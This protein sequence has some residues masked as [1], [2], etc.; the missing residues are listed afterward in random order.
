MKF[1]PYISSFVFKNMCEMVK[2]RVRTEKGFKEVHL[3][4]LAKKVFEY[5][6]VEVSSQQVYNHLR[7][8]RTT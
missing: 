4:T 1:P 7:K 2:R 6:G 3:N 5:C 8:W